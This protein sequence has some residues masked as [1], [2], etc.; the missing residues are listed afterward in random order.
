V[1]TRTEIEA[2]AETAT[3]HKTLD[4]ILEVLL[5]LR[6]ARSAAVDSARHPQS[7]AQIP[8]FPASSALRRR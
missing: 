4:L 7:L 2:E 1:R 8:T 6:E 5:D 3:E